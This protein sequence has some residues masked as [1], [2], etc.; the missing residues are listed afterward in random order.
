GGRT[1]FACQRAGGN[2]PA[3]LHQ[4][5]PRRGGRR[6]EA[7]GQAGGGVVAAARWVQGGFGAG[8]GRQRP[9][10]LLQSHGHA[11][12]ALRAAGAVGS[13]SAGGG[14]AAGA[15]RLAHRGRGADGAGGAETSLAAAAGGGHQRVPRGAGGAS[16]PPG[17]RR[18][19][20]GGVSAAGAQC[21]YGQHSAVVPRQ[22]GFHPEGAES[23]ALWGLA[24]LLAG[25]P[26]DGSA[27]AG[28]SYLI[29]SCRAFEG[30]LPRDAHGESALPAE[31][32]GGAAFG[33]E[34]ERKRKRKRWKR[35]RCQAAATG[36][37][38]GLDQRAL[39]TRAAP[40]PKLREFGDPKLIP[41]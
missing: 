11:A 13:A 5:R 6:G 41:G 33:F 19:G 3:G 23:G 20:P 36:L 15:A 18:A 22:G 35:E 4:R 28:L 25:A 1:S 16:V 9:G 8:V 7:K 2:P 37:S 31:D 34:Q 17:L 21:L 24:G 26:A 40:A 14:D 29:R 32:E 10:P 27:A 38:K 39:A 12:L 30:L